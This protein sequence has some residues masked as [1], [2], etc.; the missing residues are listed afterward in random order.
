MYG[1]EGREGRKGLATSYCD[2]SRS[3]SH[4]V[5]LAGIW[6]KCAEICDAI[7][8]VKL[9]KLSVHIRSYGNI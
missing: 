6:D 8:H 1:G 5:Y 9:Q 3:G 2:I 4:F 7:R